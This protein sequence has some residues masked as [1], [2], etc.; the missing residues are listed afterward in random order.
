MG[1]RETEIKPEHACNE[2]IYGWT[3]NFYELST[4]NN[5][6]L[7]LFSYGPDRQF[8]MMF[9]EMI[10]QDNRSNATVK[11]V[12][13][14]LEMNVT[15][16]GNHGLLRRQYE[17]KVNITVTNNDDDPATVDAVTLH[18]LTPRIRRYN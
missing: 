15:D 4:G 14:A 8:E 3:P 1:E 7:D 12:V 11:P 18:L 5:N 17:E 16:I 9:Y 2:I 10:A 13:E 6:E